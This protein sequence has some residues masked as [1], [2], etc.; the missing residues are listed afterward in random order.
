MS[1]LVDHPSQV[2]THVL[3]ELHVLPNK[4][5]LGVRVLYQGRKTLLDTLDFLRDV[6]QYSLLETIELVETAPSTDLTK[7]NEDTS[8]CLEIER[9]VTAED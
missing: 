6:R 8:H 7:T 4:F 9:L 5:D 3:V 1:N 2:L